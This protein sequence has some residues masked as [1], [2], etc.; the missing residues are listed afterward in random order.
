MPMLVKSW[1]ELE[2]QDVLDKT[3]IVY[4]SD[5]G[6]P[7]PRAKTTLYDA[8]IRTP[9]VVRLPGTVP[10][11]SVQ[12]GLF[13]VVDLAPTLLDVIGHELDSAQGVSRAEMLR[14]AEA[15]GRDA[16][17]AEANWHDFG[18]VYARCANRALPA[19]S[20]LLLAESLVEQR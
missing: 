20:E 18:A 19:H 14:D 9:M 12:K 8:G 2:R 15:P 5:N 7:F 17:Y 11:G 6:M 13:S 4:M 1:A 3:L 16:I 10:T